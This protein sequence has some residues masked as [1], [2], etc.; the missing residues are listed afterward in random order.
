MSAVGATCSDFC[1]SGKRTYGIFGSGNNDHG[2]VC[3]CDAAA[4]LSSEGTEESSESKIQLALMDIQNIP[5]IP[6]IETNK[7]ESCPQPYDSAC[8]T[9][10]NS[11]GIYEHTCIQDKPD[12]TYVCFCQEF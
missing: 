11:Y 2:Y 10:C 3:I 5:V 4:V 7:A 12:G 8:T 6:D 1:K 9:F